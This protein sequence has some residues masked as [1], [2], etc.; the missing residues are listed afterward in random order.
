MQLLNKDIPDT[1]FTWT[2]SSDGSN[3]GLPVLTQGGVS[4]EPEQ[5][6]KTA[7]QNAV[8]EGKRLEQDRYTEKV[9]KHF[10]KH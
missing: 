1:G 10:L 3:Q 6:D 4:P 8:N 5:I 2:S 7:L 9:G